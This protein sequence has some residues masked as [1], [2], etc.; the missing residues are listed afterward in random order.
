MW[1]ECV[2]ST[3]SSLALQGPEFVVEFYKA[4]P[5]LLRRSLR[6]FD[7]GTRARVNRLISVWDERKVT[8][9]MGINYLSF[10]HVKPLV[11]A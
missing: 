7:D 6:D 11:S 1:N 5:R 10:T 8:L 9:R 3:A 2:I 4:V